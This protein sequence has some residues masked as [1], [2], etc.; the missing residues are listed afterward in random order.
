MRDFDRNFA[1]KRCSE[2]FRII[3]LA[4]QRMICFTFRVKVSPFEQR[5]EFSYH[6]PNEEIDP[7]RPG[8]LFVK[9]YEDNTENPG[10][11]VEK[12]NEEPVNNENSS[13]N[14]K[15]VFVNEKRKEL[16]R[17]ARTNSLQQK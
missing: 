5:N 14:V 4:I 15:I 16:S 17:S 3:L 6:L 1:K 7:D 11:N 8:I 9:E 13:A 10:V 2:H 12:T